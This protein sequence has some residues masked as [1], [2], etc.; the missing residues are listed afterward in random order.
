[1]I[2]NN[3]NRLIFIYI[4]VIFSF[5]VFGR[6]IFNALNKP[7]TLLIVSLIIL[8]IYLF[9]IKKNYQKFKFSH[10][11]WYLFLI[12]ILIIFYIVQ[13]SYIEYIHFF[14]FSNLSLILLTKYK[15][16][17]TVIVFAVIIAIIDECLQIPVTTRV[18]DYR[19][20]YINILSA[21][22]PLF[23]IK[24]LLNSKKKL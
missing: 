11:Y 20:I 19:D 13:N 16:K 4:S 23:L 9:I 8:S 18:F 5:S 10:K 22:S 24:P 1:M 15:N 17:K 14:L 6:T 12:N 21:L 2:N 7:S 3:I